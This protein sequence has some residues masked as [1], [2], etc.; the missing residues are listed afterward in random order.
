LKITDD[1]FKKLRAVFG[2]RSLPDDSNAYPNKVLKAASACQKFLYKLQTKF[3]AEA[4]Q[5]NQ[6]E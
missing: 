6:C 4:I 5:R 3:E 2:F 1:K